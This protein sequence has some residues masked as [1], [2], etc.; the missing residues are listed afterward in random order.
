MFYT[1]LI[2]EKAGLRVWV[3]AVLAGS[4]ALNCLLA[5]ALVALEPDAR[6]IIVPPTIASERE[7]WSFDKNGPNAA[8]LE[9]F[10]LSILSYAANVTPETVDA[11]RKLLLQHVDPAVYGEIE[12]AFLLEGERMKKDHASTVF[13]ADRA[14]VNPK[15]LTAEISGVQKLFVGSTV[16]RNEKK[17]WTLGFRYDAGRLY[18]T[19]ILDSS[20]SEKAQKKS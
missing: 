12:T 9:R 16:T 6:T 11:S 20:L 4:F 14:V 8:Y 18:L 7:F 13:Y 1:T 15:T 3:L 10:A 2:A 5:I 19:Q 17:V